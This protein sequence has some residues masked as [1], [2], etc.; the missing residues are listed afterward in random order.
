[1]KAMKK[2]VKFLAPFGL[3]LFLVISAV[4]GQDPN[5]SQWLNAPIYYNPA[6]AGLYTGMI[7]SRPRTIFHD[8]AF[9]DSRIFSSERKD[10]FPS[11][12]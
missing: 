11:F 1:M 9:C 12:L 2:I 6:Y 8:E 5:Y 3:G 4:R 7:A 10:K